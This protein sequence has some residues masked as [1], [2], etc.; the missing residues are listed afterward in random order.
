[1]ASGIKPIREYHG[2]FDDK[3]QRA[4]DAIYE[5]SKQIAQGSPVAKSEFNTYIT[6]LITRQGVGAYLLDW[7]A[8]DLGNTTS[9]ARVLHCWSD[10]TNAPF[11]VTGRDDE[12][13]G[14]RYMAV[15]GT[16][17]S[18]LGAVRG[19]QPAATDIIWTYRIRVNEIDS[20][21]SDSFNVRTTGPRQ[22]V[23]EPLTLHVDQFARVSIGS[24]TDVALATV[25]APYVSLLFVPD[26]L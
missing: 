22:K 19:V 25:I 24:H 11:V 20:G 14:Q 3:T 10:G 9:S 1:M 26:P 13:R 21:V 15:A 23:K 4:I 8:G 17:I 6:N 7:G 18:M 5:W 16:I 2:A 12:G